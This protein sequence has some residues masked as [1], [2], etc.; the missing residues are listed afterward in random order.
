MS[1]PGKSAQ[2]LCTAQPLLLL[3][4][5]FLLCFTFF[6]ILL[7]DG[8][9]NITGAIFFLL[10]TMSFKTLRLQR[11]SNTKYLTVTQTFNS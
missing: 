2:P 11:H 9:H 3:C 8:K 5:F 4:A 1:N 6:D 10:T 7:F